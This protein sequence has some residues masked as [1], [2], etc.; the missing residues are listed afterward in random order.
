[1]SALPTTTGK[2]FIELH[3][4]SYYVPPRA[5]PRPSSFKLQASKSNTQILIGLIL[6]HIRRRAAS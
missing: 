3:P 4:L 2:A 6:Y 1:M 5:F